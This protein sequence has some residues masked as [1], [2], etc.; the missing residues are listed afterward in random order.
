MTRDDEQE[1]RDLS[2][3]SGLRRDL[4]EAKRALHNIQIECRNYDGDGYD[5]I[6]AIAV[7]AIKEFRYG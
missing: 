3:I 4:Y 6:E 2:L 1:I 7:A 5:Q